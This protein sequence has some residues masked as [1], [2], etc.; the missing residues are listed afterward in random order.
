MKFKKGDEVKVTVGKD[1][2]KTGKIE[3]VFLKENRVLIP[4]INMYKR[5]VKPRDPR[6][7]A[8]IIDIV[9][10]LPVGNIA[11]IC[12]KC[13]Q[14][15]RIGFAIEDSKKVRICRKCESRLT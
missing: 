9:R 7:P 2:G 14:Q 8:G 5:H 10:P 12:P 4:G 1:K 11:L 15:V 13:R 6:R 3:K